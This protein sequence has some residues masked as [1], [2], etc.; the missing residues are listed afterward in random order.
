MTSSLSSA[1]PVRPPSQSDHQYSDSTLSSHPRSK[2]SSNRLSLHSI[3]VNS[4]HSNEETVDNHHQADTDPET[5]EVTVDDYHEHFRRLVSQITRETEEALALTAPETK[6]VKPD[7]P[8]TLNFYHPRIPPTIG[9]DEFGRPYRPDEHVPI[10]NSF[11]RRMPT[12]ESMGSREMGSSIHSRNDTMTTSVR[13]SLPVSRPLTRANTLDSTFGSR[14]SSRTNSITTGAEILRNAA[15]TT[16]VGELVD[17]SGPPDIRAP[18]T[19]SSN[20]SYPS[21][22]IS[23]HT[24]TSHGSTMSSSFPPSAAQ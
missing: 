11:V 4:V 10:M 12:I 22:M 1:N 18:S 17:K 20:S 21:T 13:S 3:A 16:E 19:A 5:A 15:R 7:V 24:A 8:T 14:P 23:Y 2:Q 9:Y 6:D